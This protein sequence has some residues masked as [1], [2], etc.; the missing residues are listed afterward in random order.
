MKEINV[1]DLH[2]VVDPRR[3]E[4]QAPKPQPG[5]RGFSETLESAVNQMNQVGQRGAVSTGKVDTFS[6]QE[7]V[8]AAQEEFAKLM[9]VERNLRELHQMLTR[10]SEDRS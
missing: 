1:R 2:A 8:T 9:Q 5:G 3:S 6:I 10:K 4:R 7:E